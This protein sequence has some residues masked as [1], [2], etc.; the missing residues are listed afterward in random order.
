MQ[1]TK[2]AYRTL[3][4]SSSTYAMKKQLQAEHGMKELIAE[5]ASLEQRKTKLENQVHE[6]QRN[7]DADLEKCREKRAEW[8]KK[9]E[10]EVEF[11]KYKEQIL[12]KFLNQVKEKSK[13]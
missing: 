5:Q 7:Y 6:L 11:L 9:C 2:E 3:Y 12:T 1:A 8:Q 10:T 13:N 4:Q